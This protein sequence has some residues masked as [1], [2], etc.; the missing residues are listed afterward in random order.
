MGKFET[1]W[2][3]NRTRPGKPKDA[4][5]VWDLFTDVQDIDLPY[6]FG[7]QAADMAARGFSGALSD[8]VRVFSWSR[9]WLLKLHPTR[10][11]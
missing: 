6:N 1:N 10:H 5:S 4:A 2:L 7:L 8:K 9:E 3:S 11:R